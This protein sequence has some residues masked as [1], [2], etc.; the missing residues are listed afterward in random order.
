MHDRPSPQ[1]ITLFES[2]ASHAKWSAPTNKRVPRVPF[3][4]LRKRL[5]SISNN[6]LHRHCAFSHSNQQLCIV[7]L[8]ISIGDSMIHRNS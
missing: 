6:N 7:S 8:E 3:S 2:R 1:R 4:S 5:F